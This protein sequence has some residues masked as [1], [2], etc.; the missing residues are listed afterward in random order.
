MR[1]ELV[2][3][4]L[5]FP[6]PEA[7]KQAW[8]RIE[9]EHQLHLLNLS[10]AEITHVLRSGLRANLAVSAAQMDVQVRG[11]SQLAGQ[12]GAV[13]EGIMTLGVDVREGFDQLA[14]GM[15]EMATAFEAGLSEVARTIDT[16]FAHMA[17]EIVANRQVLT[18]IRGVLRELLAVESNPRATDAAEKTRQA[19]ANMQDALHLASARR[20]RLLDEALRELTD[21]VSINPYD[22]DAQFHLG[23]LHLFYQHDATQASQHFDTAVLRSLVKAPQFASYALRHLALAKRT[24]GDLAGAYE[25][26]KEALDLT[27]SHCELLS[28]HARYAALAG[29]TDEAAT[30]LRRL[31][32]E[33]PAYFYDAAA[34]PD[35]AG[36]RGTMD[37]L[38]DEAKA[39]ARVAI[40]S[41]MNEIRQ[42]KDE[43]EIVDQKYEDRLNDLLQAV[44]AAVGYRQAMSLA[45]KIQDT[46]EGMRDTLIGDIWNPNRPAPVVRP[47]ADVERQRQQEK[48]ER[49][50][51]AEEVRRR[52]EETV[53][54]ASTREQQQRHRIGLCKTCGR[55][56][57]F[58]DKLVGRAQCR[59][60]R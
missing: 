3:M 10:Q 7:E 53:A 30:I 35:F 22:F 1:A 60:C 48:A 57:G 23:W 32:N 33:S 13:Q 51:Q 43:Y 58:L 45:G 26:T 36:L 56:L 11:F 12:L 54:G 55:S 28:D 5:L 37:T 44:Q 39:T 20:T 34:E 52:E 47:R 17:Q 40:D 29:H 9:V 21:A 2:G 16:G 18:D 31:I 59:R 41:V 25:V 19:K 49:Q 50:R 42:F 38:L 15:E 8:H 14:E 46:I 24:A 6:I 4:N 27:P